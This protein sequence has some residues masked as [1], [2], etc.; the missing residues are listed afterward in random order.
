MGDMQSTGSPPL[1][2][3]PQEP[4]NSLCTF[5]L[6]PVAP[7]VQQQLCVSPSNSNASIAS[8]ASSQ[9]RLYDPLIMLA[10]LLEEFRA[11]GGERQ[12]SAARAEGL[13]SAQAVALAAAA[14]AAERAQA[15]ADLAAAIAAQEAI[16]G[17]AADAQGSAT[18]RSRTQ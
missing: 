17:P 8:N 12:Q 2:A 14:A 11:Q 18:K 7:V 10:Q 9:E 3:P 13:A 4:A 16:A 1:I 5:L 15:E 6:E